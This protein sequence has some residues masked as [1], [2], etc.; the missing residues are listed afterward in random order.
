MKLVDTG[1]AEFTRLSREP[2]RPRPS[3]RDASS[4]REP[5]A[6]RPPLVVVIAG[7]NGAGKSTM[8]PRLLRD[9]LAVSEFVNAHPIAIGLSAFR[10]ESV[11]MTAARV[12]LARLKS[13]AAAG[14]D[15]AFETT[16]A[17]RTFAPRLRRLRA[18]GIASIWPFCRCLVPTW[19]WPV[20]P[21]ECARGGMTCRSRPYGGALT[22]GSETSSR[23]TRA[24]Q[25][26]GNCS[27]TQGWA[28]RGWWRPGVRGT[29][30]AF[31]MPWPGPTCERGKHDRAARFASYATWTAWRI[32][33]AF[34]KQ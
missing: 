5:M 8:A 14:T 13:L 26:P 10:P 25:T 12:M 18:S 15:F 9:A 24:L 29:R 28:N 31:S 32:C 6:E 33:R 4:S 16:L 1:R 2:R 30:R 7:P 11:A 27:T 20:W 17:S 3:S 23:S 21:S 22:P 34:S 19:P